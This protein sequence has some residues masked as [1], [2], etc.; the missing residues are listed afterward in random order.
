MSDIP[1]PDLGFLDRGPDEYF[2]R[3]DMVDTQVA[4]Q[5]LPLVYAELRKLAAAKM[6]REIPGHTLQPTALV[7]EAWLRL[8]G[9]AQ[10]QWKSRAQFFAAAAESMR[11]ILIERA[12]RRRAARHG[13]GLVEVRID[14]PGFDLATPAIND[15]D[16]LLLHEALEAFELHDA[17]KAQMLKQWY[18]VGLDLEEIAA[19]LEV[20][21]STV[22]RDIRYG[23]AWLGQE[24]LRLRQDSAL[25]G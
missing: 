23:R 16:L 14:S 15:A 24:V 18:F 2:P 11:R 9:A 10:P 3:V 21:L 13:G 17:R 7:H 6:A 22:N 25:R 20:S 19:L 8:G 1:A 12:R 5:I 4:D